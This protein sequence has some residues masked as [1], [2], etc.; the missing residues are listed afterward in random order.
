MLLAYD[1]A[2]PNAP[3]SASITAANNELKALMLRVQ[4]PPS[5]SEVAKDFC[6]RL[7]KRSPGQRMRY[8]QIKAHEWMEGIDFDADKLNATKVHPYILEY[9]DSRNGFDSDRCRKKGA[10]PNETPAQ[11]E[12]RVDKMR[13]AT[14]E[15]RQKKK[16]KPEPITEFTRANGRNDIT[17]L[18]EINAAGLFYDMESIIEGICAVTYATKGTSAGE[19]FESRWSKKPNEEV[20]SL[21]KNWPYISKSCIELERKAYDKEEKGKSA[22]LE[23]AK[24]TKAAAGKGKK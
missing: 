12:A 5:I 19:K 21:F 20:D 14:K 22:L 15:E 2:D 6:E 4:Y 13:Q 1:Q 24:K 10:S 11:C 7:L 9:I 16:D 3:Q 17:H 18:Q 8:P 23:Q